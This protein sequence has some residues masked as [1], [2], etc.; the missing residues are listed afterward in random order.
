MCIRT[1]TTTRPRTGARCW[2]RARQP[3]S[4]RAT[5]HEER[6]DVCRWCAFE[7]ALK[8][9]L[10]ESL[11]HVGKSLH[12]AVRTLLDVS[13]GSRSH[14]AD[15]EAACKECACFSSRPRTRP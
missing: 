9:Q 5:Q 11:W 10:C 4:V 7:C 8:P 1:T 15:Q 6:R 14:S 2:M 13:P 12:V 3:T